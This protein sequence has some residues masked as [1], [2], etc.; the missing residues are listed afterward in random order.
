[1]PAYAGVMPQLKAGNTRLIASVFLQHKNGSQGSRSLLSRIRY[2]P[3]MNL[4]QAIFP[5]PIA[6]LA[7]RCDA[8]GLLGLEYLPLDVAELAP[9]NSMAERVCVQLEQYLR[10]PDSKF[11]VPLQLSGTAHQHK[12]WRALL[13]IPRGQTRYYGDLA[14]ELGSAAQAVGQ[15]CG[16]NPIA[17]IVPC[18]RVVGKAGLGGF[19][20]HA[21]GNPIA[22]KHWLLAHE[23]AKA[24]QPR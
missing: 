5:S 10:D 11:D 4:Y 1:M 24:A 18:H 12:V 19:M 9:S 14:R 16:A 2:H 8:L 7:I 15:A 20:Q 3:R 21:E 17:L 22:I 13:A 6:K 23:H